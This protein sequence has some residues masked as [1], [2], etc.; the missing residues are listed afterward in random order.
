MT[1]LVRA[2]AG[3]CAEDWVPD[4]GLRKYCKAAFLPLPPQD[5]NRVHGWKANDTIARR[6]GRAL[7]ANGSDRQH[8]ERPIA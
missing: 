8:R 3:C 2:D 1:C 5:C 7:S 4:N 6:V